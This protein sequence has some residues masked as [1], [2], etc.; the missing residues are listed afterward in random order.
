[1]DF[2]FTSEQTML[3]S[4]ARELMTEQSPPSAVRKW[5]ENAT[6]YDE[7]LW[8]KLAE[9]GLQGVAIP[10][11]HGGQGLGM[12]ELALVLEEMG[13]AAYPGPFFTTTV[14]ASSAIAASG[15][16]AQIASYLPRIA[17]GEMKATLAISGSGLTWS[18]GGVGVR[19]Q[20]RGG[21]YVLSGAARYVP[22]AHVA[23]LILVAAR[24]RDSG[25]PTGGIT[26]FALDRGTPGL[27]I[28]AND[29]IDLTNRSANL[30]LEGVRV[31]SDAVLSSV[32]EGGQILD[33]TLRRAA[34]GASAEMLG[35]ARKCL[36]LSVEYAK[37]R[38][39]F[40]QKIGAFQ[41]IKHYCADM[42][43]EV[44]NAHAATYYAAWAID[45][46]A[47]DA[48][49]AASVAKSYTNEA[50]RKVCGQSIQVHGGIGFT[51][52]YDLHLFFKRAKHFEPLFG[53]A[54]A[55]RELVLQEVLRS[56]AIPV[57]A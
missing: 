25:D 19:A 50:A 53:D 16:E 42:L 51:W 30:T 34:V 40:G 28:E 1:M 54:E 23:N 29:E 46:D 8:G 21:D 49:L 57:L 55:H 22:W 27:K 17:A 45:A 2:E 39:Q 10:E 52:D 6:G 4:L 5:A 38:E 36:D 20:A 15:D 44:E 26:I 32:D 11:Q 9:M 56:A 35:A 31:S 24:T 12:I 14:L 47:P 33:A 13:R 43:V 48:A 18:A 7:A 3:R 37:V 41:A